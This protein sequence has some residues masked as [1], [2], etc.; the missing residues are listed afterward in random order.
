MESRVTSRLTKRL[1]DSLKPGDLAWDGVVK[2]F[3]ARGLKSGAI[4][5]VLK[6]RS[7][8][9]QR[10]LTIGRH[11]SP[12]TADSARAEAIA[13]MG[14]IVRG[15]DPSLERQNRRVEATCQSLAQR[16]LAEHAQAKKKPHSVAEDTRM[17]ERQILPK[18]GTLRIAD[19][20]TADISRLHHSLAAHPYS[21]NRC[22]ALLSKIFNLAE[23][24]GLRP[25]GSN[26]CRHIERFPEKSRERFL[27]AEEVRKLGDALSAAD[28]E[29]RMSPYLTGLF[30]LLL[31]TGARLG[32]WLTAQWHYVDWQQ[33][34]LRLPDS[35]TG[36]K[37]IMLSDPALQILRELPHLE[38]NPYVL[39]GVKAGSHL[40]NVQKAWQR[41]RASAC[42]PDVRIHDLRHSFASVAASKGDSLVAI[43]KLLGHKNQQTTARYAHLATAPLRGSVNRIAEDFSALV[44][45][46]PDA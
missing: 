9:R 6:Y 30:R 14:D 3:G 4:V 41:L 15:K 40:V 33:G 37:W 34:A 1:V 32:E 5:Y 29:A 10:W 24:W 2:G 35:K 43:G 45:T 28:Q 8:S 22:L 46:R 16:Y 7:G 12:W 36:A 20:T 31:L 18:L 11:A 17:L 27:S 42:I 19:V 21:A 38:G 23:R 26:P 25:S 44:T 13:L 39:P